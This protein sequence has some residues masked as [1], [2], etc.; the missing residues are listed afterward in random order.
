MLLIRIL[1]IFV[2]QGVDLIN[3]IC[4]TGNGFISY[5][6]DEDGYSREK[7]VNYIHEDNTD[8]I[9]AVSG[10][11]DE[12]YSSLNNQ[13]KL[14][15]I[16]AIT[17]LVVVL[18]LISF[19]SKSVTTPLGHFSSRLFEIS[20][21]EGDLT[22]R[23]QLKSSDEVSNMGK[24]FN[25]FLDN[26]QN[27]INSIKQTSENTMEVKNR[28]VNDV[29]EAAIAVEQISTELDE[30]DGKTG[31]L[32]SHVESSVD[33]V[34]KIG[35]SIDSLNISFD[36]QIKLYE[37]TTLYIKQMID[38]IF[39]VIEISTSKQESTREL[40]KRATEGDLVINKTQEAVKEVAR[41]LD[42]IKGMAEI[43]NNLSAQTNLLSINAAIEAAHAGDAGRGFAVVADEINKLALSSSQNSEKIASTIKEVEKTINVANQFSIDTGDS[44]SLLN[45]EIQFIVEAFNDINNSNSRLNSFS[46]EVMESINSLNSHS[47][48]VKK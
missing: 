36:E 8:L 42:G 47:F 12:A 26:L 33:S 32:Y 44:F 13:I 15:I 37:S 1:I 46:S 6:W 22:N 34:H 16:V 24:N 27:M 43:I 19:V 11:N 41:Q 17:V 35:Q 25:G 18:L 10:F 21:G 5:I 29:N 48:N 9:I 20:K 40:L 23:I 14:I 2:L 38:S 28:I 7:Y 4:E 39:E 3:Q 30:I 31:D 45:K